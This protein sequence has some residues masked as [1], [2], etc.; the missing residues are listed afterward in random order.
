MHAER[1]VNTNPPEK[2]I[3]RLKHFQNQRERDACSVNSVASVSSPI[4]AITE[5]VSNHASSLQ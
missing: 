4:S 2:Q 1:V 3:E 5:G